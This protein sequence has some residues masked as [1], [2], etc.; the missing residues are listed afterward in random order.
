VQRLFVNFPTQIN[1]ENISGNRE[2]ILS[3]REFLVRAISLPGN[4]HATRSAVSSGAQL[5]TQKA[6]PGL[7]RHGDRILSFCDGALV[8]VVSPHKHCLSVEREHRR[9][10]PLPDIETNH[11]PHMVTHKPPRFRRLPRNLGESK[12]TS[13]PSICSSL[14]PR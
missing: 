2:L 10:I 3:I 6:L 4:S 13:R 9:T 14:L 1:R 5:V 8:V 7:R 11:I 12:L